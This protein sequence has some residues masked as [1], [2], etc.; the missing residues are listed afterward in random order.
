MKGKQ[1]MVRPVFA[2]AL[3]AVLALGA[4]ESRTSWVKE[5]APAGQLDYDQRECRRTAGDYG[6]IERG[7]SY[8]TDAGRNVGQSVVAEEYRR[9]M[10]LRGW[11]RE[12]GPDTA[13]PAAGDRRS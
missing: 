9:C 11:R 6:Y 7:P 2:A 3:L 4:C 8:S 10:E 12:R 13:G 1:Q 5:S